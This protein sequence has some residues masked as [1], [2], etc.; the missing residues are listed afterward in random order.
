[1]PAET[2]AAVDRPVATRL[3]RHLRLGTTLVADNGK[4]LPGRPGR[5]FVAT[6][7]ATATA[8]TATITGVASSIT[9]ALLAALRPTGDTPLGIVRET[10]LRKKRLL[11]RRKHKLVSTVG[12][13][14]GTIGKAHLLASLKGTTGHGT[15]T[16]LVIG[17]R[18]FGTPAARGNRNAQ[19]FSDPLPPH[20]IA[21]AAARNKRLFPARLHSA[22]PDRLQA[23]HD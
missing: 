4:H 18:R 15:D 17:G 12:T 8:T 7:T 13:H 5:R 19:N 2:V 22:T 3:K 11:T 6:A 20:S 14:Q 1:M 16:G 23:G 9:G 21:A 10:S